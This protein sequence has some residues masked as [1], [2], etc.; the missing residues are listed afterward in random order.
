VQGRA[1]Y[2]AGRGRA[3]QQVDRING[4]LGRTEWSPRSSTSS[5]SASTSRSTRARDGQDLPGVEKED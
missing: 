1:K 5:T 2:R 3:H 4:V